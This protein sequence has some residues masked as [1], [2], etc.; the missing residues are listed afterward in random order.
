M[1]RRRVPNTG[2]VASASRTGGVGGRGVSQSAGG[3][4]RDRGLV[5]FARTEREGAGGAPASKGLRPARRRLTGQREL[6]DGAPPRVWARP[7]TA[8]VRLDDPPT[9]GK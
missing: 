6:K 9:D 7:Q 3:R 2:R 4:Q 5:R 8:A 1:V